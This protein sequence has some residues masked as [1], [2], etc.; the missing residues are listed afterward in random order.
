[1]VSLCYDLNLKPPANMVTIS[2]YWETVKFLGG[3][4]YKNRSLEEYLDAEPF[5]YLPNIIV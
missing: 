3:G 4:A 5:L 2:C 1:M